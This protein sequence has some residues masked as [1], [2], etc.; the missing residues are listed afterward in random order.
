MGK[1]TCC[2]MPLQRVKGT[3]DWL[4]LLNIPVL[5]T[6]GTTTPVISNWKPKFSKIVYKECPIAASSSPIQ[7]IF[8]K[9]PWELMV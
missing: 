9:F 4:S 5:K 3:I 6:V 8:T 7:I 1:L 2:L